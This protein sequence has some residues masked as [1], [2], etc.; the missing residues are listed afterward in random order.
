[1]DSVRATAATCAPMM[2]APPLTPEQE[3]RLDELSQKKDPMVIHEFL[4]LVEELGKTEPERAFR[5]YV[6]WYHRQDYMN[7]EGLLEGEA[8]RS[9][10]METLAFCHQE[11]AG[12]PRRERQVGLTARSVFYPATLR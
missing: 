2:Q 7:Q 5:T 9:H 1:M 10:F 12:K 3:A 4:F 8:L 11:N 6:E